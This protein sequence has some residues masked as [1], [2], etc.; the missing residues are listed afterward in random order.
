[1]TYSP[2]WYHLDISPVTAVLL[3][4]C[5]ESTA[6]SHPRSLAHPRFFLQRMIHPPPL[7]PSRLPFTQDLT[8]LLRDLPWP[9]PPMLMPPSLFSSSFDHLTCLMYLWY[10][11]CA[12]LSNQNIS[13]LSTSSYLF[14]TLSQANGLGFIE[15]TE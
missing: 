14:P 13:F 8:A 15:Y 3:L 5:S 12:C 10:L 2:A 6:H 1:M 7:H 4:N 9:P 11:F